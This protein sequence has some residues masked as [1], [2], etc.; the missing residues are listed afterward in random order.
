MSW[1]TKKNENTEDLPKMSYEERRQKI[2]E[3]I[4]ARQEQERAYLRCSIAGNPKTGK[5]GVAMDCRTEEEIKKGMKVRGLDLDDGATPTWHTAWD[6]DPNIEIYVPQEECYRVD[7]TVDWEEA[8]LNCNAWMEET[9]EMISEGIVK[10][11]VLDGVDKVK[12]ASSDVFREHLVKGARKKGQVIMDTDSMNPPSTLDWRIRNQVHDRV[13]NPFYSLNCDVYFVTH[14]KP[15]YEGIAVPVPIGFEPDWYKTVPQHMF[16]MVEI[17]ELKKGN[18]TEY[19]ARLKACK[20]NPSLVGKEWV[21]FRVKNW[22]GEA[23]T[24]EDN[25]WF[26]IPELKTGELK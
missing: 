11:V 6:K 5:S 10:A 14:M 17:H 20:T 16:Q 19:V 24:Q 2:R 4:K 1:T 21:V 3:Q 26:G 7:G 18:Y 13:V 22:Q 9:R 15:I 12:D 23:E 8:F 25:E